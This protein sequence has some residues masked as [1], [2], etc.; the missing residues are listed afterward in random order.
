MRTFCLVLCL[1]AVSL[2]S[3]FGDEVIIKVFTQKGVP[4][5]A[6]EVLIAQA[7]TCPVPGLTAPKTDK[8]GK[9]TDEI[10]GRAA[11]YV[12]KPGF[13]QAS[14]SLKKGYNIFRMEVAGD[15]SGSVVDKEGNPVEGANITVI[16][17]TKADGS[18]SS[19][20]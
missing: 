20:S 8:F 4:V 7:G 3:A 14:Q 2:S 13:V 10:E 16:S 11:A 6:A 19:F 15:V 1:G 12:Y 17:V 5:E 18:R 9:Y